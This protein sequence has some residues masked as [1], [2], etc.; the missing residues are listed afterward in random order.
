MGFGQRFARNMAKRSYQYAVRSTYP[1]LDPREKPKNTSPRVKKQDVG[2]DKNGKGY[3][4]QRY[5]K[6]QG[7]EYEILEVKGKMLVLSDG[8][9]HRMSSCEFDTGF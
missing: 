5:A 9:N 2:V 4:G 1:L 8:K 3:C 6:F 7:K